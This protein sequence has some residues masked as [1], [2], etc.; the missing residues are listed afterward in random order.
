MP[1]LQEIELRAQLA[2][3]RHD[4][5]I[6]LL[7]IQ[8][9]KSYLSELTRERDQERRG[10]VI[11]VMQRDQL[12]DVIERAVRRLEIT[13]VNGESVMPDWVADAKAVIASVKVSA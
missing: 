7:E 12:L 11:A 1:T 5:R 4:E 10:R 2:R 3:A 9:M 8:T 6:N 13:R